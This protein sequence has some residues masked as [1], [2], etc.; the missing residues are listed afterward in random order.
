MTAVLHTW[1]GA[2]LE[3]R[4]TAGGAIAPSLYD[5]LQFYDRGTLIISAAAGGAFT[6]PA[7]LPVGF[8]L[9]VV[10]D[11]SVTTAASATVAF[12]AAYTVV[13][14]LGV[15][16]YTLLPGGGVDI[17]IISANRILVLEVG[18]GTISGAGNFG[19]VATRTALSTIAAVDRFDGML[20]MVLTDNSLWRFNAASAVAA[21]YTGTA[22]VPLGAVTSANLVI[23]P[24]A[25]TG[26]WIRADKAFTA[27]YAFVQA[28]ADN[29]ALCTVPVGMC[30][31]VLGMPYFDFTAVVAGNGAR[32]VGA[33]GSFGGFGGNAGDFIG[34][35][36]PV[37][38][39]IPG[40]IG[41]DFAT[42]DAVP[43]SLTAYQTV[44]IR[45]AETITYDII[46]AGTD[47]AD[48]MICVPVAL[49]TPTQTMIS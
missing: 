41:A 11:V 24:A 28:T 1:R 13:G 19:T 23:V 34:S 40:T 30:L 7:G 36:A 39:P 37:V 21:D 29:V 33:S 48:G 49:E 4:D 32:R 26:R 45:E 25:G 2:A 22:A 9:R 12:N 31:R 27:R 38:G 47:T 17:E 15:A 10:A 18:A 43:A 35:T 42:A 8:R 14:P 3:N 46:A 5:A 44:L 6:L 16:P 20:R